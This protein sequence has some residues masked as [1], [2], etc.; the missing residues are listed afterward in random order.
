LPDVSGV[1][2]RK[3]VIDTVDKSNHHVALPKRSRTRSAG[4]RRMRSRHR[5]LTRPGAAA[6]AKNA[7]WTGRPAR[8][9]TSFDVG[10]ASFRRPD[11]ACGASDLHQG[12]TF[13][14]AALTEQSIVCGRAR[15][16]SPARGML[17]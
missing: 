14:M 12:S 3:V 16:G 15:D 6:A 13:K 8:R 1:S 10:P 11:I 2:A 4:I 7:T 17:R 9:A 5:S